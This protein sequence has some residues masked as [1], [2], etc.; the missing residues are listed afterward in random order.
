MLETNPL[1]IELTTKCTL[2]CPACPRNNP[3]ELKENWDVG[4]LDANLIKSFADSE[5]NRRYLFVGCYGDPLYHPDFIDIMRHYTARDKKVHVHTNGSFKTKKYWNELA[6]I[7]W[8]YNLH[9]FTFSV[10][11]LEDTN[12]LYR[13][14]ANWKSIM[15]GMTIMGALPKEKRPWLEWKYLVFPYNEHQV[16]EARELANKLGFDEFT[17]VTS[18]RRP[19]SYHC[20]NP[21]IYRWP[22][23]KD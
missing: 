6:D 1:E 16:E 20:D 14:R 4:H 12:H 10:D 13:I 23:D 18:E 7:N 21:E 17:P 8:S 11:G 3:L 19:D 9:H 5:S 2:G 22:D 15:V